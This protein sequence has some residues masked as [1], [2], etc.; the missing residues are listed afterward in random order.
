MMNETL[1]DVASA[2]EQP[3]D[4]AVAI[5]TP[6][7][8]TPAPDPSATD[9]SV[10]TEQPPARLWAGKYKSPEEIERAYLDSQ[11]EGSRMA[12]ELSALKRTPTDAASLEPKWKQLE[13]ER[14]KW[15]AQYRNPNVGESERYQADEQVRL[16]DREIAKQQAISEYRSESR[17]TGAESRM[18]QESTTVIEQYREQLS[19]TSSDLYRSAAQRLQ[20]LL[21]MGMPDTNT[22]KALAISHAAAMTGSHTQTLVQQD[23]KTLLKTL[24]TQ[25]RQSV[26]AGAGGPTT[27][28]ATGVT[29]KEIEDMSHKDFL[30][31]ERDLLR[32][33]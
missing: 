23:R 14:N 11:R 16:Y 5:E 27:I 12:G 30:K 32:R 9:A 24:N 19:D 4:E 26:V 33:A 22:T 1:E 8:G 2:E 25:A 31:Y 20:D 21:D 15:A 3:T 28:R 6:G 10:T 18:E 7:S 13:S 29:A 17:R